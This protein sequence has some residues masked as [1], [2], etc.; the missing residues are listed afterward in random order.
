MYTISFA[1]SDT[2]LVQDDK[3][4]GEL[5]KVSPVLR[6]EGPDP[7][8]PLARL[9]ATSP[10]GDS[11]S[12]AAVAASAAA[13]AAV[14]VEGEGITVT[15][16][17]AGRGDSKDRDWS[18][19]EIFPAVEPIRAPRVDRDI[20]KELEA[21]TGG[22]DTVVCGDMEEKKLILAKT[23]FLASTEDDVEVTPE[24]DDDIAEA[25]SVVGSLPTQ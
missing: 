20:G 8:P 11:L 22:S 10:L 13:T 24:E 6:E 5:V 7:V 12:S 18:G 21:G 3:S 17:A 16:H 1:S 19:S 9:E 23:G 25:E 2:V 14:L 15:L 4:M